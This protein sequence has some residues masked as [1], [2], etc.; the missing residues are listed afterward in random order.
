MIIDLKQ[1]RNF[2]G[3]DFIFTTAD[4]QNL[5]TAQVRFNKLLPKIT[6]LQN[7]EPVY[8]LSYNITDIPRRFLESFKREGTLFWINKPDGETCGEI[9]YRRVRNFLLSYSYKQITFNS[10]TYNSYF[11]GMGK[12]GVY[13]CIYSGE[14]L[15]AMIEKTPVV[16][17]L[18]DTYKLYIKDSKHMDMVCLY[19]IFIDHARSANYNQYAYKT[20]KISYHY[21][22]SNEI[23]AKYDPSFKELCK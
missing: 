4:N 7:D 6:L 17:D 13:D 16:Y 23:R 8:Y 1:T 3:A 21:T 11:V 12:E 10:E 19:A 2:G 18:K 9:S 22:L 20:K 15:I 5:Y 14:Q